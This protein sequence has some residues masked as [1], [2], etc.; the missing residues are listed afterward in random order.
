[1]TH[2]APLAPLQ[3]DVSVQ[4]AQLECSPKEHVLQFH[5][6]SPA[7]DC[8][9][10]GTPK[11]ARHLKVVVLEDARFFWIS[12]GPAAPAA[13]FVPTAFVLAHASAAVAV[14]AVD[15]A[16]P[17]AVSAPD[18]RAAEPLSR[19]PALAAAAAAG[20]PVPAVR[21]VV[22][23]L[24]AAS[25]SHWGSRFAAVLFGR[26]AAYRR[27]ERVQLRG[28]RYAPVEADCSAAL[29]VLQVAQPVLAARCSA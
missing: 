18:P 4:H 1:M 22:P 20:V 3:L 14:S 24:A 8:A 5:D 25:Y 11:M 21:A 13:V 6:R 26:L 17:S 9:N 23:A 28:D 27:G 7:A 29:G 16:A 2:A 10:S 19:V 15:V 12:L